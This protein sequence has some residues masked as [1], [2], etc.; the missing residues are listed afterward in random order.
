MALL[1]IWAM[2]PGWQERTCSPN[3]HAPTINV[4]R[5]HAQLRGQLAP[6]S[7]FS[8]TKIVSNVQL[9]IL[10]V[11]VDRNLVKLPQTGRFHD[12]QESNMSSVQ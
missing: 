5:V 4:R 3:V 7:T 11:I 2:K 8:A 10:E 1:Y 12:K 6:F 9:G